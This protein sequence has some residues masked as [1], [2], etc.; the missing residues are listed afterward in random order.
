MGTLAHILGVIFLQ[1]FTLTLFLFPWPN[2][3]S[4]LRWVLMVQEVSWQKARAVLVLTSF[5]PFV[6]AIPDLHHKL[7]SSP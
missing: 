1:G 2:K 3:V 5:V 7:I 4:L 6:S